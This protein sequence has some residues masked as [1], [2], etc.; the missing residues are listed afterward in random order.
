MPSLLKSTIWSAVASGDARVEAFGGGT[1]VV[2][3]FCVEQVTDGDGAGLEGAVDLILI[4]VCAVGHGTVGAIDV[5]QAE[6][7][8]V[9]VSGVFGVD[10]VWLTGDI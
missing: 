5:G 4:G 7:A 10:R 9:G 1:A 6:R 2:A 8:V 3:G